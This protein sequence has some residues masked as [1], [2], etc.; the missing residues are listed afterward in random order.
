MRLS[1]FQNSRALLLPILLLAIPATCRAEEDPSLRAKWKSEAVV[2][3]AALVPTNST[4]EAEIQMKANGT[5]LRY[6]IKKEGL[7]RFGTNGWVYAKIH[8]ES[9]NTPN[10]EKIGDFVLAIDHDG[11]LYES[12]ADPCGGL[13]IKSPTGKTFKSLDRFL[14]TLIARRHKWQ[15]IMPAPV[16]E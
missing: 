2:S 11:Q 5:I 7:V 15:P 4:P 1:P 16:K 14:N 13:I 8:C 6:Y 9:W 12:D 3:L 10:A